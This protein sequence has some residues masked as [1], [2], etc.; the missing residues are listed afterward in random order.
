MKLLHSKW[1]EPRS[2]SSSYSVIIRFDNLSGSD[3]QPWLWRWL[4]LRL[5]KGQSPTTVLFRT[6]LTRTITLYE[7]LILLGSNHWLHDSLVSIDWLDCISTQA[8]AQRF[9]LRQYE[10]W[11]EGDVKGHANYYWKTKKS[12]D[13]RRRRYRFYMAILL[14][15]SKKWNKLIMCRTARS[16]FVGMTEKWSD[17]TYIYSRWKTDI[18]THICQVL[19]FAGWLIP[20][21]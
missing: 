15:P 1:F 10:R 14:I 3:L 20:S 8:N 13:I 19:S 5:S 2:I 4:P 16:S 11:F 18:L 7:L 6:T 17:N 21:I 9:I 12:S